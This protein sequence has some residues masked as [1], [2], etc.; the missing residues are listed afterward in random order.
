MKPS[1]ISLWSMSLLAC[2]LLPLTAD[3]GWRDRGIAEDG[4]SDVPRPP[5]LVGTYDL[6]DDDFVDPG[7]GS[8]D[9]GYEDRGYDAAPDETFP[10]DDVEPRGYSE[11]DLEAVP[12]PRRNTRAAL[13][14]YDGGDPGPTV[15]PGLAPTERTSRRRPESIRADDGDQKLAPAKPTRAKHPRP[16]KGELEA[17]A[18]A[19]RLAPGARKPDRKRVA[20]KLAAPSTIPAIGGTPAQTAP[21]GGAASGE[22]VA[23][24][25]IGKP[26]ASAGPATGARGPVAVPVKRPNLDVL[27][28]AP[29][30]GSAGRQASEDRR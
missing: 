23:T 1:S 7:D 15:V 5:G 13:P 14:G 3:A 29:T 30:D 4:W 20:P 16:A 21:A 28:F 6:G 24:A 8:D 12:E 22:P 9:P 18:A 10:E 17:A 26:A 2:A 19:D 11:P 27:D 25:S